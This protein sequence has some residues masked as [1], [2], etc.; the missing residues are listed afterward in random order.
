M[1][2]GVCQTPEI[3][4]DVEAALAVVR[5]FAEQAEGVDLLVFPECFLQG[6]S[7]TPEHVR[8]FARPADLR[9]AVR[10][11]VVL[12]MIERND[13]RYYN[14]AAVLRDGRTV[15]AYRKTF[16]TR[17]EHVFTA[18]G[19]Y[20]VFD[21]AGVRFGINICFD[22]Q[23]PH[24]AAAVRRQNAQL[25]V[26]PAQN[27]MRRDKAPLWQHRHNELR[28]ERVRET[29]MWLASA[30]VTGSRGDSHVGLGPTCVISPAGEI[31]A[32]V[33]TGTVGMAV[34]TIS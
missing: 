23:Y 33:P 27:M 18:G 17:G 29:G 12:G 3:L 7:V 10:P 30:D 31:V 1:R 21:C 5:E 8:E 13:D 6:Y 11:T 2:V 22:A 19:D 26:L 34:A 20:P 24:A 32:Q 28:R 25:L 4:G 16:L 14:T 15:G 9:L